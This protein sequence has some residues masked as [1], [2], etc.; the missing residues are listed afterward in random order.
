MAEEN[1]FVGTNCQSFDPSKVQCDKEGNMPIHILEC[2][3]T[4]KQIGRAHV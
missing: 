2:I 3:V 4:G 1:V